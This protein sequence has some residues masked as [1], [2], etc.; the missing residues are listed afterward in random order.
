MVGEL[1][2][3]LKIASCDTAVEHLRAFLRASSGLLLAADCQRVLLHLDRKI[4][5]GEAR[6]RDGDAVSVFGRP[7][8]I[9]RRIAGRALHAVDLVQHVEQPVK[10]NG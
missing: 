4:G 1:K 5:I 8:D 3:S 10:A 7:L 6:D 9:I 2:A